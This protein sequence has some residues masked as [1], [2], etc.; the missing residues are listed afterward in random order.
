M[1]SCLKKFTNRILGKKYPTDEFF[2]QD[3]RYVFED[4]IIELLKNNGVLGNVV[5]VYIIGSVLELI[6]KDMFIFCLMT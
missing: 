3:G 4:E 6:G 5:A 1:Q 2:T